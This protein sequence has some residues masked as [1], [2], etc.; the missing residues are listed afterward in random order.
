MILL[1]LDT[2]DIC[3]SDNGSGG[4]N[5]IKSYIAKCQ[6][7][8]MANAVI[9]ARKI[10]DL[11]WLTEDSPFT[12]ISGNDAI[13]FKQTLIAKSKKVLQEA[14]YTISGLSTEKSTLLDMYKSPCCYVIVHELSNGTAVIQG[15]DLLWESNNFL[16]TKGLQSIELTNLDVGWVKEDSNTAVITFKSIT[17]QLAPE[18]LNYATIVDI[19]EPEPI[20]PTLSINVISNFLHLEYLK[21]G[22][23]G[24]TLV[25]YLDMGHEVLSF[26]IKDV[27]KPINLNTYLCGLPASQGYVDIEVTLVSSTGTVS[28]EDEVNVGIDEVELGE[29]SYIITDVNGVSC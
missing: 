9:E 26:N 11:P 20:L 19:V 10:T 6:N 22:S 27:T 28:D 4:V 16:L 5:V 17:D 1:D 21:G 7:V 12:I 15:V 3:E 23:G 25:M 8:D 18:I 29:Q 14:S 24:F 13:S 2:E